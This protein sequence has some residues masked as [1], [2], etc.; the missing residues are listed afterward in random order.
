MLLWAWID[1]ITSNVDGAALDSLTE[2]V[3]NFNV[4]GASYA[5]R[6]TYLEGVIASLVKK[7]Q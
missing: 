4:N 2:I 3:N 7:S 5:S 1:F 6:L